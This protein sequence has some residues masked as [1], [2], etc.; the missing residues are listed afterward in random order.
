MQEEAWGVEQGPHS[1]K[2]KYGLH[3][4]I[5]RPVEYAMYSAGDVFPVHLKKIKHIVE[6]YVP[7]ASESKLCQKDVNNKWIKPDKGYYLPKNGQ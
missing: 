1:C 5:A 3:G 2:K 7:S 4:L 6:D